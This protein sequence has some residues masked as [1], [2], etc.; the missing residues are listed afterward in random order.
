M[1]E[2]E[3]KKIGKAKGSTPAKRKLNLSACEKKTSGTKTQAKPKKKKTAPKQIKKLRRKK[4]NSSNC[5]C[6]YCQ[7]SYSS[8]VNGEIWVNCLNPSCDEWAHETCAIASGIFEEG[9][10]FHCDNCL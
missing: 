6:F 2:A 8:N 9:E 10:N 7:N 4:E 1:A 5:F 3:K